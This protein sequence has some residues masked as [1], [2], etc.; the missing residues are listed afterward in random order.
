MLK[1]RLLVLLFRKIMVDIVNRNNKGFWEETAQTSSWYP[2]EEAVGTSHDLCSR[3]EEPLLY[4]SINIDTLNYCYWKWAVY[5]HTH[6][7]HMCKIWPI[8][9]WASARVKKFDYRPIMDDVYFFPKWHKN[10][11][12]PNRFSFSKKTQ[13]LHFKVVVITPVGFR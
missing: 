10:L 6:L 13:L 2:L 5:T 3:V 8:L 12:L 7:L 1:L 9:N 11:N 4:N